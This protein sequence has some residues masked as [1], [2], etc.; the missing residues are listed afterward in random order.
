[1]RLLST[2]ISGWHIFTHVCFFPFFFKKKKVVPFDR[3]YCRETSDS[4]SH[5][6]LEANELTTDENMKSKLVNKDNQDKY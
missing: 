5:Q 3:A 1:M 6:Y 4:F 2:Q